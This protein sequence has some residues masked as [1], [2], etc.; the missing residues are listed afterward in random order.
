MLWS[1]KNDEFQG[2]LEVWHNDSQGI[3]DLKK[4]LRRG[5]FVERSQVWRARRWIFTRTREIQRDFLNS[6]E[7]AGVKA[8]NAA[9]VS[10]WGAVLALLISTVAMGISWLVY[11]RPDS[12]QKMQL[13]PGTTISVDIKDGTYP[14]CSFQSPQFRCCTPPAAPFSSNMYR[15][16]MHDTAMK[17]VFTVIK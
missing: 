9:W 6:P 5:D 14:I 3:A 10:A 8:A 12:I 16:H 17:K 2:K 7:G 15:L 1:W 11:I 4:E 13:Q